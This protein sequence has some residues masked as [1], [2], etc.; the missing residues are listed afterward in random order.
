[1]SAT[2]GKA[3]AINN[4]EKKRKRM[5]SNRE[6]ARRSRMRK[7]KL[8]EDLISEKAALERSVSEANQKLSSAWQRCRDLEAENELLRAERARLAE[9]CASLNRVLES[10]GEIEDDDGDRWTELSVDCDEAETA[11]Q[12]PWS[13]FMVRSS[14]ARL[15]ADCF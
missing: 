13:D 8:I 2:A 7:Q 3:T 11:F 15:V 10:N 5:I 12:N 14:S 1:M 6:S 4:D 9:Y